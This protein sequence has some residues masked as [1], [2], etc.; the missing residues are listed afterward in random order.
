MYAVK[1]EALRARRAGGMAAMLERLKN[2]EVREQVIR[3]MRSPGVGWENLLQLSGGTGENITLIG[4]QNDKL[5]HLIGL[6][7]ADAA[8]ARNSSVE[9]TIIDLIIE[10][11]SRVEAAYRV[12]SALAITTLLALAT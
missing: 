9:D 7:L 5:A 3:E 4:F 6:S 8:R 12:M 11:N 10:D 1:Q 2:P